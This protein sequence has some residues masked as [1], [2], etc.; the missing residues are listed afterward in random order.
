MR[1]VQLVRLDLPDSR[2]P[3][4]SLDYPEVPDQVVRLDSQVAQVQL[5]QL[6]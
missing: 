2:V 1:L 5:D 3:L 6:V 4:V